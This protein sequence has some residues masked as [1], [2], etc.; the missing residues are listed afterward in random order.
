MAH[1]NKIRLE[2]FSLNSQVRILLHS[3]GSADNYM[4]YSLHISNLKK[5]T[6]FVTAANI[7]FFVIGGLSSV[8]L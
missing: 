6:N 2:F 4:N 5:V 1:S 7:E 3:L 8:L